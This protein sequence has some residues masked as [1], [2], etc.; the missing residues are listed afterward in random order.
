MISPGQ[1]YGVVALTSRHLILGFVVRPQNGE[2]AL[3]LG[4][5][6]DSRVY[7]RS[8]VEIDVTDPCRPIT[9]P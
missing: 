2:A 4:C 6:T 8:T 7:G 9:L 1:A 5:Y 3:S